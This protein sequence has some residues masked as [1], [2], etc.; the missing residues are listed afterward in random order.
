MLKIF[1]GTSDN[2]S[3]PIYVVAIDMKDAVSIVDDLI[4]P[5]VVLKDIRQISEES[6]H[7]LIER[8]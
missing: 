6:A 3:Y 5:K 4:N 1:R 7:V 2:T 8:D